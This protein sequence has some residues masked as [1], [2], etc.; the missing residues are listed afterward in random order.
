MQS[1]LALPFRLEVAT[2]RAQLLGADISPKMVD[3]A[4][5]HKHPAGS[6]RPLY[7]RLEVGDAVELLD[8]W[9]DGR[10]SPPRE[11]NAITAADVL[12]YIGDAR[13]LMVAAAK[14]FHALADRKPGSTAPLLAFTT[15]SHADEPLGGDASSRLIVETGRY[16]HSERVIREDAAAAGFRVEA[17]TKLVPGIRVDHGR[18]LPGH[19]FVLRPTL[20][21]P[22]GEEQAPVKP[23]VQDEL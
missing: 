8:G 7:D 16:S 9:G 18:W 6:S 2:Q 4:A 23:G 5:Q 19:V 21:P 14:A 10:R 1:A 11:L 17:K 20:W 3:M 15:E 12:I 13:P 22:A